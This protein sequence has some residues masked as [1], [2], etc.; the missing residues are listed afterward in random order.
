MF[1]VLAFVL[2]LALPAH[3]KA[4]RVLVLNPSGHITVKQDPF[5]PAA[6]PTPAPPVLATAASAAAKPKPKPKRK[7]QKTVS[8][9]LTRLLK[10]QAITSSQYATYNGA[11]NAALKTQRHLHGTPAKELEAVIENMHNIAVAGKLTPGRLPALFLTLDYNRQW[12]ATGTV[13]SADSYVEFTGSE[14]RLGVLPGPGDRAPGARHVRQG[15][16][17]VH[18]P[19]PPTTRRWR[20]CS[21]R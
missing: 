11:W 7:P 9:E 18:R 21:P 20:R 3:A 4:A 16:R 19:G 10:A 8:S 14:L 17:P 5:V 15:R 12:W 1:A 6:V 2:A 13:L